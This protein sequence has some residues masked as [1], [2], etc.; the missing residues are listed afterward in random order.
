MD[1]SGYGCTAIALLTGAGGVVAG[2]FVRFFLAKRSAKRKEDWDQLKDLSKHINAL[3]DEAIGFYC[4]KHTDEAIR[5]AKAIQIQRMIALAAQKAQFLARS[6]ENQSIDGYL[7]RLRQAITQGDGFDA[8]ITR[9][10]LELESQRIV[11][12][13]QACSAFIGAIDLAFT[14]SHR[15]PNF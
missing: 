4:T 14:R 6:L 12:I 9:A 7:K 8:D 1:T 10:P 2:Y 15:A 3:V 13:D 5:R 11:A